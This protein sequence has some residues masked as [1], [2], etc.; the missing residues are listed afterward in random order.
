MDPTDEAVK[1]AQWL[2]DVAYKQA[3]HHVGISD[4]SVATFDDKKRVDIFQSVLFKAMNDNMNQIRL[5]NAI[6]DRK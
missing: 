1:Q 2:W 3:V 4:W 6:S 5:A